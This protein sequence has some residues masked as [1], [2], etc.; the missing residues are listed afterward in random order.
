[1]AKN[2]SASDLSRLTSGSAHSMGREQDDQQSRGGGEASAAD[3]RWEVSCSI[4]EEIVPRE[5]PPNQ[6]MEDWTEAMRPIRHPK[7]A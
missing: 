5:E 3:R 4:E 7:A 1:M 2:A 6:G